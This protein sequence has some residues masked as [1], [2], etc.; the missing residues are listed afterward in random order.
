MSKKNGDGEPFLEVG[1]SLPGVENSS[2]GFIYN[3]SYANLAECSGTWPASAG[4]LEDRMK[5]GKY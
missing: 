2:D 4:D 3:K 5:N 1:F